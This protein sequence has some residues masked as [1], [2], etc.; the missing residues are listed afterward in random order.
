MVRQVDQWDLEVG[1]RD[2]WTSGSSWIRRWDSETSGPVGLEGRT[3]RQVDQ[4]D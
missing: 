2:K 4:W 3:V 1:Q